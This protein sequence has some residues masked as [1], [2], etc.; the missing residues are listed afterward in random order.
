MTT[1]I[2]AP[3]GSADAT[4]QKVLDSVKAI[5]G[6]G[7]GAYVDLFLI[8]SASCGRKGRKEL[9]LALERLLEEG[10]TRSIGVSNFGA[11][12]IEEMKA[13]AKVW[14]PQVNQLEVCFNSSCCFVGRE[15]DVR[16]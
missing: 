13:Y 12:H 4:Y 1:K 9:W 15:E 10:K 2:M 3:A 16:C 11:G 7:E 6:E 14:P 5:G 8:H